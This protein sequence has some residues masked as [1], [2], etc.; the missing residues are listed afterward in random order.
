MDPVRN[1]YAPGAGQRPPELAGRDRAALGGVE[2]LYVHSPDR[3]ARKYL[4]QVL[5]LEEFARVG[6]RVVFLNQAPPQTP[7]DELL[8]SGSGFGAGVFA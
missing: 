8:G 1:P 2:V 5:L 4:H 3:L 6:V 7:E